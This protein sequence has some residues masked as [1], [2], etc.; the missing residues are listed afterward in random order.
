MDPDKGI[1]LVTA[2]CETVLRSDR[3]SDCLREALA[4]ADREDIDTAMR[5]AKA[6]VRESPSYIDAMVVLA[7]LLLAKPRGPE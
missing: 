6:A 7:D 5:L 3:A 1:A 2:A 4:A